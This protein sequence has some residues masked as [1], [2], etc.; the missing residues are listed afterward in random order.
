MGRWDGTSSTQKLAGS[1]L[2]IF[3]NKQD[4]SGALSKEE[5][6]QLLELDTMSASRHWA[7]V[8]CSAMTGAGLL[9]GFDWMVG[10]IASRI[11]MFD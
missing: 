5:I 11:Y 1:S 3:A 9:E 4:I 10:D 7:I 6:Q 8:G 2:L